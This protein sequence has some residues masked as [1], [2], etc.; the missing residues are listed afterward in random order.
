M[1]SLTLL[2]FL[3]SSFSLRAAEIA[4]N[5]PVA[6]PEAVIV[7]GNARFTVLTPQLIRMEWAED[8][9]FED[10]ASLA[11]VNRRLEV[12]SFKKSVGKNSVTIKTDALTL[13]YK[14]PGR[15]DA[16][17]LSVEF[18]MKD[19]RGKK[20]VR[21]VKWT[22]GADDSGNLMGTFRT[23]DGCKGFEQINY[24]GDE[25]EK[26]V[27]SRD[28]W[29]L[30]DESDR[31][32]IVKD[33][34]DWGEWVAARPEGDRLDWYLFA[35]G[36]EYKKALTD[37]TKVAG[38]IPLPPKF[39][40]GY[41][42]SRYW[43]YSDFEF[44]GLGKEIRSHG[45][46]MDVMVIDM[47]WHDIWTLQRRQPV[48]DEF[49]Q[50]IGW[51]GYT[52]QKELF[53][54][55]ALTLGQL[56]RMNMKTSLNLHPASG[57]QPY[58]DCYEPFVTDYL[59]RTTEY[60][61]PEGYRYKEGDSLLYLRS[62]P[63]TRSARLAKEGE[64]APVP[65]RIDQKAWADAY[66]NSVIRPMERQGVD[67]WWLD[68]QQWKLSEYIPGLSNT[69]WLNH[70][71]FNDK[72]RQSKS[73][74]LSADRPLIYHRW[75]GLGSHRYQIGFSGD[76][77]DTWDVLKFL[78]YFTGTSSNVGYGY[79]GHDIGGHMVLGGTDPYKPE[80]YTRWLQYGVFTPIFKTH[81]TKNADIERRVW[82]YEP[83]YSGPMR[84]AIR[85]RYDLSPYIYQ[86]ARQ[87]YDTGIS[88]CR[89]M[90]Y[91]WAENEEAYTMK[92]QYMFGDAILA[93]AVCEPV[94]AASG[95]A[96]RTVWL[97][98]GS[99]WYDMA[100]GM[101]YKGGQTLTLQY[102][103]DENPWYVKAGSIIPMADP[104]LTSLQEKSNVLR[105]LVVPGDGE[106]TCTHYED[107][108]T[109][110]A[111]GQEF[112]QTRIVKESSPES[113]RVTVCAREGSYAGMDPTRRVQVVLEG[114]FVPSSVTLSFGGDAS[115]VTIPYAAF[116]ED[117]PDKA[118]WKY[119]GKDLAV[120]VS[121]PEADA[122]QAVSL[123]CRYDVKAL[124]D[125]AGVDAA[126]VDS[127]LLRGKKGLFNRMMK[128]TPVLKDVFNTCVD[129]YKLLSRPFLK[130]AQGASHIDAEPRMMV[131]FLE[132]IDVKSVEEDFLQELEG[133]RATEKS[134]EK[135]ERKA[136]R[137]LQ[138]V[139]SIKAQSKL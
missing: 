39:V 85:L 12:P 37:F 38:K 93:T 127:R 124:A 11:I 91:D 44:I 118:T 132:D 21:K 33:D 95:L 99:D 79:W 96:P 116:P 120:V 9:L 101:L 62:D 59:S 40:F 3:I 57:I 52:W 41:W 112:A 31:H 2:T 20:G 106:S 131:K 115:P 129:P 47:D 92:E 24:K 70:T 84:E 55:P 113:C 32:L 130:L 51:T 134:P 66:F 58:E 139:E 30:V 22:P 76:A 102:T 86:A 28:G 119:V 109:S 17:N 100:T 69:F 73:L 16:K 34:S 10:N 108:G 71:F 88:I 133:M 6:A 138:A 7:C 110:Q 18:T 135:A 4:V 1:G 35:Y 90:Y 72:V 46:P 75:G 78:P 68:W 98:Q 19:A 23:L 97:P 25:Y 114:V 49:G 45:I 15:F 77:Y 123:E 81:C 136:A 126:S 61:G 107:D 82:T 105:L 65:F 42:W 87:A 89:P 121:L 13:K 48:R 14:G 104:D 29:A 64:K 117:T 94:D 43:Q 5:D 60:D 83:K 26:G 50:R 122:S 8:G 80:I 56:H 63:K 111:Y 53:P 36:H 54:D 27:L 103:L 67:F 128:L 125:A 137:I 74:G